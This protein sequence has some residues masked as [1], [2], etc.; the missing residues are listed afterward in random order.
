MKKLFLLIAVAAMSLTAGAQTLEWGVHAGLNVASQ[1]LSVDGAS[2]SPDS[3][4]Q[5][6]AGFSLAARMSND[7]PI[8]LQTGLDFTGRGCESQGASDNLYYL[9]LPV[10]A[11]YYVNVGRIVSIRPYVGLYYALGLFSNAKV[12]GKAQEIDGS[13]FDY[14]SKYDEYDGLQCYKRSDF[15]LRFGADVVLMKHYSVGLGY[16]LGLMNI[17][18]DMLDEGKIRNGVFYIRL[19]YNF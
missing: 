2:V 1:R 10:T 6:Q 11:S 17:N 7:L 13:K 3:H 12:E 15:G 19:G 14:F 8:Y 18:K 4:A 9:Q 16:D 5:F